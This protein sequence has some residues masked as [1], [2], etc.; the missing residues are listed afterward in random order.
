MKAR[1]FAVTVLLIF[2]YG[3]ASAQTYQV[4][5]TY[6]TNLRA[7]YSLESAVLA[8]AQAGTTVQVVGQHGR[9]LHVNRD[10]RDY[11]MASWVAYTRIQVV[12]APT[13]DIDNCC[14]VD[15][16]C[17]TDREWTDGYWAYQGTE[18][19]A[20]AQPPQQATSQPVS[21]TP[22][23]VDN[24]CFVDRQCTT[25]QQ[26]TKGYWAYQSNQCR[27]PGQPQQSSP[28]S[29]NIA[30]EIDNCCQVDWFCNEDED[31]QR[32]FF[33]YL[34]NQCKWG[35]VKVEGS[36]NFVAMIDNAF[37]LLRT[38]A[39]NWRRYV[40]TG[41]NAIQQIPRG[42]GSGIHPDTRRYVEADFGH[43]PFT[44]SD[45]IAMVGNM[46]HEACHM[47]QWDEGVATTGWRNE[48]RCVQEQ[49]AASVATDPLDRNGS[50]LRNLI[51]NIENP[52]YWWWD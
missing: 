4:R 6:N 49:L 28:A 9:W 16:Q 46:V 23:N 50:W 20:P 40:I 8:S 14:F 32:G 34:S 29:T 38:R 10:G 2:L 47:H 17:Q 26:W 31:W 30:S 25:D 24:C 3:Q 37:E 7:S 35:G 45:V 22:V 51:A 19:T 48:I 41:L 11:W 43:D 52:D 21:I 42:G 36:A 33:A 1:L 18:C 44:E 27:A 15:R 39:P 13:V 12:E 5:V